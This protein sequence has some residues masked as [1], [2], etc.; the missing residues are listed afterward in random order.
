MAVTVF[1]QFAATLSAG[2]TIFWTMTDAHPPFNPNVN[3]EARPQFLLEWQAIPI[4]TTVDPASP[5]IRNIRP[6]LEISQVIIVQEH[7]TSHSHQLAITCHDLGN[8]PPGSQFV[9]TYVLYAI[10]TDI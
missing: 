9:V 2:S 1:E 6:A 3:P 7:D 8:P 4:L 10:R 5:G